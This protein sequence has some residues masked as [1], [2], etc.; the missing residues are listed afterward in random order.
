MVLEW[1]VIP[2]A[3][4]DVAF[5]VLPLA[6]VR[7]R[8]LLAVSEVALSLM[9]LIG[10]GL[11]IRSFLRLRAVPPGFATDHVI[12][13]AAIANGPRYRD[14]AARIEFWREIGG[15]VGQLPGVKSYKAGG[16]H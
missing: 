3:W 13:M 11:L 14:D 8:G 4:G 6:G 2:R 1:A 10:A 5:V 15:R 12:S 7:L 16:H 9:L